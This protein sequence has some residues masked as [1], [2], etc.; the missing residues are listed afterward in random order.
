MASYQALEQ[1]YKEGKIKQIGVS[2]YTKVHL[3]HLIDHCTIIPHVHQFEL[4]PCL[5][6]PDILDL[7]HQNNIQIQA[8]SSLGEGKLIDGTVPINGLQDMVTKYNTTQAIILLRWAI[9]HHY[10]IIPKSKSPSRVKQNADIWTIELSSQDMELLDNI[11]QTQTHR[12]CWDPTDI[13]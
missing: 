12:F 3:Q 4:H 7:C 2:N 5:Y 6:Q 9:Q 1:L 8:Y 10:A 11:H 13:F